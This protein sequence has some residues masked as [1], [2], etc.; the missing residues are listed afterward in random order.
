MKK[1]L[2]MLLFT[3]LF[4]VLSAG[5]DAQ[6]SGKRYWQ[7]SD[8]TVASVNGYPILYTD[9]KLYQL[10]FNGSSFKTAL[11]GVIDIYV[12][13]QYATSKGISI[14]Y[15]KLQEAIEHFA[16][17]Q[18]L[19]VDQLYKL[20]EQ[21]GI[22]AEAFKNFIY[23][24]NLYVGAIQ[25]FV[26]KPL[27]SDRERL[28]QLIGLEAANKPLKYELELLKIPLKVAE[29]NTDLLAT[30]NFNLISKRLGIEPISLTVSVQEVSK[31]FASLLKRMKPGETNFFQEG[32]FLYII[33]LKQTFRELSPVQER[34]LIAKIEE[35]KIEE[36][37]QKL[38]NEAVIRIIDEAPKVFLPKGG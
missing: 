10:L 32:N 21:N 24:Y 38:R 28:K 25:F 35:E 37:V 29:R 6:G 18:G 36:F 12:V 3:L 17:T 34:K 4:I 22:S 31:R 15:K 13:S 11:Q 7:L 2:G 33:H 14:P 1:T 23:R 27:L 26:I 9:V 5:Y 19:S 30:L 8:E 20:L 16:K